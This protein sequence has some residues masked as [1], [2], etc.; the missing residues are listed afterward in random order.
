[1][2]VVENL[3]CVRQEQIIF[4]KLGFCLPDGAILPLVGENGSG[5]SSLL[6][7]IAGLL[8][9]F[10]GTISWGGKEIKQPSDYNGEILYLGHNNAIKKESSVLAELQFWADISGNWELWMVAARY[11]GLEKY[12]DY[13]CAMLSAGWA[14]RVALARLITCP[15]KLWLLDEPVANLDAQAV[16]LFMGLVQ[17]KIQS[18]GVVLM[19]A[20]GVIDAPALCI[21]D[22]G[23]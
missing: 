2:L 21:S 11:F 9:A 14:R 3:A 7:I 8:P 5:K 4:S 17:S 10:S 20:H 12:L 6:K 19:A 22:F 1:M 23:A 18:G 15:A 16:R 13:P